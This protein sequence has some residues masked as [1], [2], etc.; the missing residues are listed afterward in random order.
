LLAKAAFAATEVND[1]VGVATGTDL[2]GNELTA[3]DRAFTAATMFL[4]G[5]S[6]GY[7]GAA[8]AVGAVTDVSKPA[9]AFVDLATPQ[10]RKH[11][12]DGDEL[13]GGHRHGTGK[14]NKTEF[15]QDWSDDK[16]MHEISD[17]ATDPN[18]SRTPG[19]HN[20]TVVEGSRDGVDIRVII[21]APSEKEAGQII[22]GFP[23]NL[24]KNPKSADKK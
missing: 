6:A 10:R 14:P 22:S 9:S 11:I 7:K 12:L 3:Q 16:I 13:G 8:K 1:A 24:P 4:P 20:R 21:G 18:A 15:P 19:E 2:L 23:T 17:V 5:P